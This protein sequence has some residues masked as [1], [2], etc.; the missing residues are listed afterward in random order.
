MGRSATH[1]NARS[2]AAFT[3]AAFDANYRNIAVSGMGVSIGWTNVIAQEIWDRV[4]P[5]MDSKRA[6][7]SDYTPDVVFINL[8]RTMTPLPRRK[9]FRFHPL[10]IPTDM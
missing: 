9:T 8:G 6:N 7:L 10:N 3:A 5:E 1:N 4:Y 2:Y